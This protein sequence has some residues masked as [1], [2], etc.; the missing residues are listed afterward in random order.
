MTSKQQ[1]VKLQQGCRS[2]LQ[3]SQYPRKAGDNGDNKRRDGDGKTN[4]DETSRQAAARCEQERASME[5]VLLGCRWGFHCASPL[6]HFHREALSEYAHDL[7]KTLRQAALRACGQQFGYSVSIR[8]ADAFVVFQI[9]E[10]RDR[11]YVAKTTKMG[12]SAGSEKEALER[13]GGFVLYFPTKEEEQTPRKGRER[14]QVLLLRGDDELLRWTCSWLQRR[15]QCIVHSQVVRIQQLNLKRLARNWTVA[16][17]LAERA[18]LS[19]ARHDAGGPKEEKE[20]DEAFVRGHF[21]TVE[22][23][24]RA[25][26]LLQYRAT[27]EE[28]AVRTY[29]LTIPWVTLRRLF[30]Q[31]KDGLGSSSCPSTHVPE[32]IEL[33]K[34]LYV[35]TLPFDLATYVIERIE[36]QEV[37]VD[38]DGGVELYSMDLVHAVL[39]SLLE[40]LTVQNTD[41]TLRPETTL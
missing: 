7:V 2:P 31:T 16:S 23:P 40:L 5:Q 28:D 14:K 13:S 35:D 21:M 25:P 12:V 34:R 1:H 11:Q 41:A 38:L 9:Q 10:E 3:S 39:F 33:T 30:Q 4:E 37:A 36:M 15:F 26:L 24:L 18:R 8:S 20:E 32:L 27:N 17:L 22:E 29:T 6:F 19:K